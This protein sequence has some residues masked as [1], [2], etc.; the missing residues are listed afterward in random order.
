MRGGSS[1]PSRRDRLPSV[2]GGH[3][4][5]R[6]VGHLRQVRARLL[7]PGG[8]RGVQGVREG[9]LRAQGRRGVVRQLH[10]GHLRRGGGTDRLR[11][12][13]A[14]HHHPPERLRLAPPVH[15]PAGRQLLLLAGAGLPRQPH[16][17]PAQ[18]HLRPDT[19]PQSLPDPGLRRP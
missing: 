8:I 14:L 9:H 11:G 16:R 6:D 10:P 13:P 15:V 2:R 18:P 5:R 1:Q 3:L 4:H 17:G 7:L 12:L 19:R